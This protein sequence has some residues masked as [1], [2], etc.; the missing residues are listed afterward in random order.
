MS[1]RAERSRRTGETDVTVA[2]DVDG[3][4]T[5]RVDT[6]VGFFDHMLTLLG[7]HGLMDLTVRAQGDL[8]TGS[9]H[10]VEDVGITLGLALDDALGD[11]AGITRYG[12]AL[13]PMDECLVQAAVD[14]SGRPFC[15]VDVPL[16]F[17][18]VGGFETDLLE[19]FLRALAVNAR[20]TLHVR[21][22][23]GAN[24]HHVIECAF[25][26]VARAVDQAC[27]VDPRVTGVPS[28][29]GSL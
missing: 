25:K 28:T 18:T 3:T 27:R 6:G 13:I 19:E 26:A 7:R 15:A 5:A 20:M 12:A 11:R 16:P 29:K 9:H 22:L 14:V 17:G 1:R 23:A 8:E 24:P 21:L 4:G 10:T 2:V